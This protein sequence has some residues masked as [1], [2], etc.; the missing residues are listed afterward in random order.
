MNLKRF[1]VTLGNSA[2]RRIIEFGIDSNNV[3]SAVHDRDETQGGGNQ[4]WI[5]SK[6][7]RGP[8]AGNQESRFIPSGPIREALA[9]FREDIKFV[10][11]DV[12]V[13]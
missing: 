1:T 7:W 6:I 10:D 2:N 9:F 8:G 11:G 3:I 12:T 4:L 5:T 13:V